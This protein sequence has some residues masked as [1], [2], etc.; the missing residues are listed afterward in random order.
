MLLYKGPI[1]HVS[2]HYHC[3]HTAKNK[4]C[5]SHALWPEEKP[6]LLSITLAQ[7]LIILSYVAYVSL[8]SFFLLTQSSAHTQSA[9]FTD[10][11]ACVPVCIVST[12][13]DTMLAHTE[14]PSQ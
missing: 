4:A 14:I 11:Y 13:L 2:E 6:V 8:T 12:I 7:L 5:S 3:I 9:Q 1:L 10:P